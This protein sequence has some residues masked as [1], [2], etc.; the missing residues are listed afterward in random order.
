MRLTLLITTLTALFNTGLIWTIQ[1]VHYPGFLKVGPDAHQ[2]YHR[3]HM[4]AITPLVGISMTFELAASGLLLLMIGQIPSKAL[5]IAAFILLVAIWM[6]TAFVAVPLHG[7]LSESFSL[8]IAQSLVDTNW[9]RTIFWTLRSMI[10]G[11]LLY[12]A[13]R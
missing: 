4:A 8:E 9:W 1:L 3:F 7:K 2:V 6:H 12:Q 11:Y 13:I 10:L 5:Y